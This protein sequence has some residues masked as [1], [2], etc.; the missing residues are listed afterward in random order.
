MSIRQNPFMEKLRRKLYKAVEKN[1]DAIL[2]KFQGWFEEDDAEKR[3][4]RTEKSKK[5]FDK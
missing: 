1:F 4:K 3:K 5:R 2:D